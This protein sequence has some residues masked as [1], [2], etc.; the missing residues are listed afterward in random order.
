MAFGAWKSFLPRAQCTTSLEYGI[1]WLEFGK[2]G[3]LFS[4]TDG[5]VAAHGIGCV[6]STRLATAIWALPRSTDY[7]YALEFYFVFGG[8]ESGL[9]EKRP[10]ASG[11]MYHLDP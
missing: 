6:L 3:S 7:L 10:R 2:G 9:W 1:G 8:E 5:I 11:L 4:G